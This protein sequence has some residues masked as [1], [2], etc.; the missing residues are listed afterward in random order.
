MSYP[1]EIMIGAIVAETAFMSTVQSLTQAAAAYGS[2]HVRKPIIVQ[3]L[4]FKVSTA[5]LDLTASVVAAE[6]I[7]N[8]QNATPVTTAIGSIT[9]PNGATAQT[10]YYNNSFT[11]VVCP[12]NSLLRFKLKTQGALGG[13]P[14]GAGYF[15]WYGSLHVEENTNATPSNS[16]IKV[17]I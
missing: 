2:L 4:S 10:T 6:V 12:A 1:R 16:M 7:T 5:V 13:T 9:I 11:P 15:G 3:E 14:A 8:I 17:T